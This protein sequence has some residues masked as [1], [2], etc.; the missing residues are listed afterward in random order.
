MGIA[1]TIADY[2]LDSDI[3]CELIPHPNTGTARASSS[4]SG[5]PADRVVEAIVIKDA[6]AF[7]LALVP[8]SRHIQFDKLQ[9]L[10]GDEVNIAGEKEIKTLFVNCAPRSVP[11]FRAVYEPD[12]VMDDSLSEQPDFEIEGG[13]H[14]NLV[15]ISGNFQKLVRGARHGRFTDTLKAA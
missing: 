1:G 9:Q 12:V 8:A 15:R 7:M 2:L 11:A 6:D 10:V 14:A 13:D 3:A 4:T 5:V